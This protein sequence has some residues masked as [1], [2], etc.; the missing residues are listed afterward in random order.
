[1]ACGAAGRL[2]RVP[3][4]PGRALYRARCCSAGSGPGCKSGSDDR[5]AS[6][7][8]PAA[9]PKEARAKLGFSDLRTVLVPADGYT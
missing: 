3:V 6:K 1:M 4:G 7:E 5:S 8:E 2:L 9:A